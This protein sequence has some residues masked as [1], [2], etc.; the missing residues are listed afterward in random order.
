[1]DKNDAIAL[2]THVRSIVTQLNEAATIARNGCDENELGYYLEKFGHSMTILFDI[3]DTIYEQFPD[4]RPE[5]YE[6][7]E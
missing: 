3:L 6:R 4:I 1:M 2:S 5:N 7:L